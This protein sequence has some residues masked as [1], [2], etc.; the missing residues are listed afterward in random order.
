MS[1]ALTRAHTR[2]RCSAEAR[3]RLA[4]FM[5]LS[6]WVEGG[7]KGKRQEKMADLDAA[8]VKREGRRGRS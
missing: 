6:S 1:R 5:D 8:P 3:A 7:K 4:S 2:L